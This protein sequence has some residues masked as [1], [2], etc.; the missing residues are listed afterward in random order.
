MSNHPYDKTKEIVRLKQQIIDLKTAN[1]D[2]YEHIKA[3]EKEILEYSNLREKYK[4]L[5]QENQEL[6]RKYESHDFLYQNEV[7][8]N[9]ALAGKIFEKDLKIQKIEKAIEIIKSKNVN[10]FYLAYCFNCGGL[11]R[12]NR[13]AQKYHIG[14]LKKEE[15]EL[16]KEVFRNGNMD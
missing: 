14:T 2:K 3:M 6:K 8:K 5:Y 13:H 9:G 1:K 16:L 10:T 15:H 4:L 11:E 7:S 12:Y